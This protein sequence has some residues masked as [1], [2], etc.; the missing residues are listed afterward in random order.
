MRRNNGNLCTA[1]FYNMCVQASSI[2]SSNIYRNN[3]KP[4][5]RTGNKV[6]IGICAYNFVLFIGAKLFYVHVHRQRERKWNSMTSEEKD[7]Y[8]ATT[9]D[10]GNKRLD[11][12]FAS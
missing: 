5:Y 4:L 6:L 12:R 2:I 7:E 10:K 8:L 3:D 11:F 9:S 1:Q